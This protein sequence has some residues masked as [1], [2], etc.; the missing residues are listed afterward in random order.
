[1]PLLPPCKLSQTDPIQASGLH[2]NIHRLRPYA[3][4]Q[5][6]SSSQVAGRASDLARDLG[7]LPWVATA[8]RCTSV[9]C[10]GS[11]TLA[12]LWQ[13]LSCFGGLGLQAGGVSFLRSVRLSAARPPREQ[14]HPR[15]A[16]W[17]FGTPW[18]ADLE[19]VLGSVQGCRV[20]AGV[21]RI[22]EL[23][24]GFDPPTI[25]EK[26]S[27]ETEPRSPWSP[28]SPGTP[29]SHRSHTTQPGRAKKRHRPASSCTR[30][31]VRRRSKQSNA[32]STL[33]PASWTGD[34]VRT[35]EV[36]RLQ[37]LDAAGRRRRGGVSSSP[38]RFPSVRRGQS[39]M[40]CA[41]S[42]AI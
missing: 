24:F 32:Q 26:R 30:R 22:P 23:C 31:C 41:L 18:P 10:F 33:S 3:A 20:D 12:S 8:Q 36:V 25:W 39:C 15:R 28:W 29:R 11:N 35:I 4:C 16:G 1:M 19:R 7:C 27:S 40:L 2:Q 34:S 6:H 13:H 9:Q 37:R 5:P 17:Q 38:G 21:I 42:R 14:S